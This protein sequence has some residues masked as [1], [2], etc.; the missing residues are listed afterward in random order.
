MQ[1]SSLTPGCYGPI[2]S[3]DTTCRRFWLGF[4]SNEPVK[5][6]KKRGEK[7]GGGI[8]SQTAPFINKRSTCKPKLDKSQLPAFHSYR[9]TVCSKPSA[10]HLAAHPGSIQAQAAEAIVGKT[11]LPRKIRYCGSCFLFLIV[12]TGLVVCIPFAPRHLTFSL[13]RLFLVLFCLLFVA[14]SAYF[15]TATAM[16]LETLR[17]DV[18]VRFVCFLLTKRAL[19]PSFFIF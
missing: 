18:E 11:M 14:N 1:N 4:A 12:Q 19:T 16:F 2:T 9:L 6:E 10:R 8:R 7:K 15:I 17:S 3:G 13:R 5:K